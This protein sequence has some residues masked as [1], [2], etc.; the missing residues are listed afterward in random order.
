[1]NLFSW[2]K[3]PHPFIF[4]PYSVAIPGLITLL[5]LVLLAPLGFD[6]LS[7]GMR[8]A[9]GLGMGL[10][11][12]G[13]V[14]AGVQGMRWLFP[15][16]MKPEHWTLG[17]EALLVLVVIFLIALVIFGSLWGLSLVEASPWRLF[18][19]VVVY[20]LAISLFP[21]LIL[22]LF[23]QF[24]HQRAKLAQ[25]RALTERLRAPA[26]LPPSDQL[27]FE[28]ENGKLMLQLR[29]ME[30][31]FLKAAG[32]YVEVFYQQ[33]PQGLQK[34]LLRN[35]LKALA[36]VLPSD[37]FFHCHKSYLVNGHHIQRVTGNARNFEL[38]LRGSSERVPVSRARSAALQ[39]F[40][41]QLP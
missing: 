34:T 20:T 30:V 24:S 15:T 31:V 13:C 41:R 12:S 4:T 18:Q 16:W 40:L 35:R 39:D 2:L 26:P 19:S 1:M 21:L 28:A 14:W 22:V 8:L 38:S 27:Q 11:A 23:E 10:L 32:N 29:P 5:I 7:L 36:D 6:E 3:T 9:F 37:T 33:G 25:A 17:K